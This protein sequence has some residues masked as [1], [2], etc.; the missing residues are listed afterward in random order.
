MQRAISIV[1]LALVV[2][3]SSEVQESADVGD[4]LP[5]EPT[6]VQEPFELARVSLSNQDFAEAVRLY[7]EAAEQGHA[8]AQFSL[9]VLTALGQGVTRDTE[10]A[11][12]LYREAANRSDGRAQY[13]L[14]EKFDQG[15]P[16]RTAEPSRTDLWLTRLARLGE[17]TNPLAVGSDYHFGMDGLAADAAEA[18]SWYSKAAEQGHVMAWRRLGEMHATGRGTSQDLVR[19]HMWFTLCADQ[20]IGGSEVWRN[21]LAA[22]MSPD[23]IAESEELANETR[24]QVSQSG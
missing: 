19:A 3:C 10:Q 2:G 15:V 5:T 12:R 9:G 7:R 4:A 11:V 1:F 22:R 23:E 13:T 14:G 21:H 17:S 8:G 16:A 24:A 20:G 6:P 18:F